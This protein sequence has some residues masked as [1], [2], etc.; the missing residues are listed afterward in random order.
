MIVER[1]LARLAPDMADPRTT[2]SPDAAAI[3]RSATVL[4]TDAFEEPGEDPNDNIDPD[5]RG[6]VDSFYTLP[7]N[8]WAELVSGAD[9]DPVSAEEARA[10]FHGIRQ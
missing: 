6:S 7:P 2:H 9:K 8:R 4:F 1:D 10:V 5:D 3:D